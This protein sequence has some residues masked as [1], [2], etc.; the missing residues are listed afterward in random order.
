MAKL[1]KEVDIEQETIETFKT[2]ESKEAREDY[3]FRSAYQVFTIYLS[4]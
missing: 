4:Y 1:V 3:F 2:S